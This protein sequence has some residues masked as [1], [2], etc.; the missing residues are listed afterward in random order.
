MRP[1][2]AMPENGRDPSLAEVLTHGQG[3]GPTNGF[4]DALLAR[5]KDLMLGMQRASASVEQAVRSLAATDG[6]LQE[7]RRILASLPE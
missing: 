7:V 5:E 6:A 2:V 1:P 4:R 3:V